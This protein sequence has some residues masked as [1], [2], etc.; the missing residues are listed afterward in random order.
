MFE[1]ILNFVQ[2]LIP[3]LI[4][5]VEVRATK[6]RKK[7]EIRDKLRA[8]ESRLSMQLMDAN[9]QLSEVT[10][11]ALTNGHNNGNVEAAKKAAVKAKQE[12][13]DFLKR[14]AADTMYY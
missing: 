8:E 14:S 3:L 11:N 13:Y 12:Y 7:K 1:K 5:I 2:L 9:C 4:A 10:A 6:D